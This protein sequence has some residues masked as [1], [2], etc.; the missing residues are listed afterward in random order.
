[1]RDGDHYVVNGVKQFISGAGVSDIYVTM[2]RT[3]EGGPS[4]ISTLVIEKDT[5][6][7]LL[8]REGEEDGLERAADRA[9]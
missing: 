7:R 5:P 6:G 2:V 1:M 3:G 9:P 4:G 8:R